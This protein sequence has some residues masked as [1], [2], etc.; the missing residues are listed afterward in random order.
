MDDHRH[1]VGAYDA[2]THFSD[3]LARVERGESIVI[4]KH[5]NPV[6]RLVPARESGTLV[7]RQDA[8]AQ[9]RALAAQHTLGK[10]K[11][12]DLIREGRP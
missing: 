7:Q 4:T 9:M 10:L 6:A 2:K 8:I 11:L 3:L 12:G 5:G 1:I